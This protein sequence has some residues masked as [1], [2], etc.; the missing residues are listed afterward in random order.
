MP[1]SCSRYRSV[2]VTLSC[3]ECRCRQTNVYTRSRARARTIQID[4]TYTKRYFIYSIH[5]KIEKSYLSWFDILSEG[6]R[7]TFPTWVEG[8]TFSKNGSPQV[9]GKVGICIECW[10]CSPSSSRK[11]LI[12]FSPVL[13]IFHSIESRFHRTFLAFMMYISTVYVIV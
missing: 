7:F 4:Y 9:W 11:T 1:G 12:S 6:C 5:N 10:K 2:R 8:K 3:C 13:T